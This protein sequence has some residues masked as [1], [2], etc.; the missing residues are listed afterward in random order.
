MQETEGDERSVGANNSRTT[1][2]ND[3]YKLSRQLIV[4]PKICYQG[5]QGS[6]NMLS[7]QLIVNSTKKAIKAPNHFIILKY[8]LIVDSTKLNQLTS[9]G[10]LW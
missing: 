2:S 4:R 1:R 8:H 10:I 5:Y 9:S 3:R 7:R 6:K